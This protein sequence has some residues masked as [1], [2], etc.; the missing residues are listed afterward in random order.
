M[1]A[2]RNFR[3]F[4]VQLPFGLSCAAPADFPSPFATLGDVLHSDDELGIYFGDATPAHRAGTTDCP[5][6]A[7]APL[8]DSRARSGALGRD[9]QSDMSTALPQPCEGRPGISHGLSVPWMPTT[10]P[11]GQSVSTEYAL[12]PNA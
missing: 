4:Q 3:P 1:T 12:V 9:G 2:L 6:Q 10:P 7:E 8:F 11:P 5:L